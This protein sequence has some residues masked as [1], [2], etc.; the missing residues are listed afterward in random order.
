MSIWTPGGEIPVERSGNDAPQ[1]G[2]PAEATSGGTPSIPDEAVRNAAE[3]MGIDPD[4]LSPEER[5]RLVE[6]VAEMAEAQQR[7]ANAPAGEVVANHAM[8]L[9][10]F[11]AIKLGTQPPQLDDAR[12]AI[13]ALGGLVETAGDG[14]GQHAAALQQALDGIRLAWVQVSDSVESD[15]P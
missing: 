14:L 4:A 10:E 5:Q 12:L 9:Y 6:I 13:D 8:G 7:L 1:G 15:A 11:A 3:A 2:G